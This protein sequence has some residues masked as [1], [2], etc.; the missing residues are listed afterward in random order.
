MPDDTRRNK[1]AKLGLL[2]LTATVIA[3]RM[4]ACEFESAADRVAFIET[5]NEQ[6]EDRD[7]EGIVVR[8]G[9]TF[10]TIPVDDARELAASEDSTGNDAFAD[11]FCS[12]EYDVVAFTGS[13]S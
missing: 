5:L 9:N 7:G 11:Q 13:E 8:V 1:Y 2:T 3:T 10:D 6:I 12:G 4:D